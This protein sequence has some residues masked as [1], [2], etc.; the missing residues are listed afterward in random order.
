M[1]QY[2]AL[3]CGVILDLI[4]GDPHSWPHPII[5][6]GRSIKRTEN[7][8]RNTK[9]MSLK[10]GGFILVISQLLLVVFIVTIILNVSQLIHPVFKFIVEVYLIY[11]S[12]ASRCLYDET[13]KVR[14]A[15]DKGSIVDARKM[16]SYLVGRDTNNLDRKEVTRATIETTAE[17]TID[18]VLAP[19]FYIFVGLLFGIPVQF[20]YA[21]KTIN[22]LDSMVGYIQE[23]YT[24]IGYAS[25][26]IDDIANFIPARIGSIFM[27]LSGGVLGYNLKHGFKI[28]FRDRR[29][30][31]SPNCGYPEAA[32]AGLLDI[33]LGGINT[34][35]G[36][37]MYKPT[38]GKE[39]K[40]LTSI[41]ILDV[42]KVMFASEILMLVVLYTLYFII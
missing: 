21:Y 36:Q 17:N 3:I 20:V 7:I 31:K 22:T 9:W 25:A 14:K 42:S 5:Y 24:E 6:I 33:Q 26:K 35:F 10:V 29:N 34:Y 37:K 19:I 38:I 13:N 28:L 18:G 27:V 4:I 15:L 39:L 41:N 11:A 16:L 12:L 32:V 23:P 1:N 40:L 8:I 30:H 2:Y